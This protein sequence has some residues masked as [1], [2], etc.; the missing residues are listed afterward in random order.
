MISRYRIPVHA[1][2]VTN[3]VSYFDRPGPGIP[4]VFVHGLGNSA[5]NFASMA[6]QRIL[7][8]HRLLAMD[9]PGCG[10]SPYPADGALRIDD[11]V[12][13]IDAFVAELVR[14]PIVL[15][16][17]SMGGLIALLYAE[18]TPD[19]V[20]AFVNAEGNLKPEDCMFSRRAVRHTFDNF[21][22]CELPRIKA[23]VAA[24]AGRGFLRHRQVLEIADPRAYYDYS[25]QTVNYSDDGHLLQR[26]LALRCRHLHFV[27]GS[28]NS[29]LS[30]LPILR[31]SRCEVSEIRGADHFMFYDDP[32]AFAACVSHSCELVS[33]GPGG[34]EPG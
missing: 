14:G 20:A 28:I 18:R 12:D 22:R 6:N 25:F 26:F 7:L 33:H 2:G 16:G 34:R 27:Y 30:Y 29:G 8:R 5:D 24:K 10:R 3:F 13:L 15:V 1:G 4:V 11:L 32:S 23:D 19:R 17:A 9:L 31:D 21:Q